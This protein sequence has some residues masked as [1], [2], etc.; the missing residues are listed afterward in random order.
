MSI[1]DLPH[2]FADIYTCVY[3]PLSDLDLPLSP[4]LI[5]ADTW[6]G[7]VYDSPQPVHIK[8]CSLM[9]CEHQRH[10]STSRL[11]ACS[12]HRPSTDSLQL[13]IAVKSYSWSQGVPNKNIH[14]CEIA[15]AW[16]ALFWLPLLRDERATAF[17]SI[18]N[19]SSLFKK[20]SAIFPC[21]PKT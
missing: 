12:L 6:E 4:A 17:L 2:H 16:K 19:I 3:V 11:D 20:I 15:T 18:I 14:M 7:P 1:F 5:D 8:S 21:P 13:K 9:A 10:L